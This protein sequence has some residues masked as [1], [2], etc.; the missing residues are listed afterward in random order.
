MTLF[1]PCCRSVSSRLLLFIKGAFKVGTLGPGRGPARFGG[2]PRP[3]GGVDVRLWCGG[4][5][6]AGI[7][8][9]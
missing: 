5:F 3:S 6:S 4:H 8:D 7:N 9:E 2:G 1:L